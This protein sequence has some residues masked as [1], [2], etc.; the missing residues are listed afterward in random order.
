MEDHRP[1]TEKIVENSVFKLLFRGGVPIILAILGVL[2][3]SQ[4]NDIKDSISDAKG[5]IKTTTK[6]VHQIELSSQKIT[7]IVDN[8]TH[9]LTDLNTTM[10]SRFNAQAKRIDTQDSRVD[11]LDGRVRNLEIKVYRGVP[12]RD[13]P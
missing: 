1:V 9:A 13:I 4:F 6:S 3:M 11:K 7:D 8:N 2:A 10:N 12:P 5:D